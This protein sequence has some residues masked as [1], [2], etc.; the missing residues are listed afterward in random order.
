[1]LFFAPSYVPMQEDEVSYA[2]DGLLLLEGAPLGF[3]FAPGAVT[4]WIGFAYGVANWVFNIVSAMGS[5]IELDALLIPLITLDQTLFDIYADMSS[6]HTVVA[7][8][9]L[10]LSL[11]GIYG[12][13]RIG[14]HFSGWPGALLAGGLAAV[15]PLLCWFGVQ[16]RPY[17][18]AWSLTILSISVMLTCSGSRRWVWAGMIFG[19]SVASRIEM[20]FTIPLIL[21]LIW[22][23]SGDRSSIRAGVRMGAAAILTFFV[24]APWF[25]SHLVGN[26]RKMITVRVLGESSLETTSIVGFM[27]GEGLGIVA[28][29][30]LVG[31]L[32]RCRTDRWQA[33]VALV[34]V[35]LLGIELLTSKTSGGLRHVG[36]AFVIVVVLS[37]YALGG[38][39]HVAG[40]RWAIPVSAAVALLA[41]SIP[42]ARSLSMAREIRSGWVEHDAVGWIESNVP[43]GS[44][45]FLRRSHARIPLPTEASAN[46]LWGKA[47]HQTAWSEKLERRLEDVGVDLDY[48]P[49]GLS[50]EHMYQELSGLRRYF[51]LGGGSERFRPR[52]DLRLVHGGET[53]DD[54]RDALGEFRQDGGVFWHSGR[55]LEEELGPPSRAWLASSGR[56]VF[57]YTR[58]PTASRRALN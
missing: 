2:A 23:V 54:F 21:W 7:G 15:T 3:K 52:Y 19:L 48:L 38:V 18:P 22:V 25:I 11:G 24:S 42:F 17:S 46:R 9:V 4:T 47:A 13:I 30:T 6:L 37:G 56:G 34:Y 5:K 20:L 39:Q 40:K 57:L 45:V 10:V 14:H 41:I 8:V 55:S 31:L 43:S 58:P 16:S 28:I 1:M 36:H 49:R 44:R 27:V 35:L 53:T 32:V 51:M 12:A 26:V 33:C 50:M 29:V